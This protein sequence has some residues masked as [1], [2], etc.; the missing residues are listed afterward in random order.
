[1]LQSS[2]FRLIYDFNHSSPFSEQAKKFSHSYLRH[3]KCEKNPQKKCFHTK[4]P[5]SFIADAQA[6]STFVS[7]YYP[8]VRSS[9]TSLEEEVILSLLGLPSDMHKSS[10]GM[11]NL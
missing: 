10:S 2:I 5:K 1:M 4:Q 3:F 6:T 9:A 7:S 8:S 11:M